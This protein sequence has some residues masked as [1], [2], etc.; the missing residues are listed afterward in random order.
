MDF[1]LDK[2]PKTVKTFIKKSRNVEIH[3]ETHVKKDSLYHLS[4]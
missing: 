2:E 1:Y 4:M 3:F